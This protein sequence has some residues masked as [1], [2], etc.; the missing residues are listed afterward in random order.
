MKKTWFNQ[1]LIKPELP[2]NIPHINKEQGQK[3]TCG[4]QTMS[5]KNQ[6]VAARERSLPSLQESQGE[7]SRDG[8]DAGQNTLEM[9][10]TDYK[11]RFNKV[12]GN[13]RSLRGR[14]LLVFD[15]CFCHRHPPL[16][17]ASNFL[18]LLCF[19]AQTRSKAENNEKYPEA[20]A[21]LMKE[22][23]MTR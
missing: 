2:I 16:S 6:A 19:G 20:V 5:G 9:Y 21:G 11:P 1:R 7:L 17:V 23:G 15:E 12:C 10:Y 4:A 22:E 13:R 14:L 18:L 8:P 3:V